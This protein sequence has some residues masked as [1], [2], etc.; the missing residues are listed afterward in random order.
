ML[1]NGVLIKSLNRKSTTTL[2]SMCRS[3]RVSTHPR[4]CSSSTLPYHY[5]SIPTYNLVLYPFASTIKIIPTVKSVLGC[6][7]SRLV[8]HARSSTKWSFQSRSSEV[9]A[10]FLFRH[11]R[12]LGSSLYVSRILYKQFDTI[13]Q[14][15]SESVSM[16]LRNKFWK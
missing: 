2:S 5:Y 9:R 6:L 7:S 12:C 16:V 13:K 3:N 1:V 8:E 4:R 11:K 14:D 15:R 10:S